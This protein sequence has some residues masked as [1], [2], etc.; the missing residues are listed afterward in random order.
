M[1][2]IEFQKDSAGKLADAL[3]EILESRIEGFLDKYTKQLVKTMNWMAL[4]VLSQ[5]GDGRV[6]TFTSRRSGKTI[7]IRPSDMELFRE[8]ELGRFDA[9]GKMVSPPHSV[10]S[11]VKVML[12]SRG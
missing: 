6:L 9:E 3:R 2:R 10:I 1:I 5:R 12:D 11:E 7:L 8:L 4:S